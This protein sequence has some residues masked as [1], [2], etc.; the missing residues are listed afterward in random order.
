MLVVRRDHKCVTSG[1][2]FDC[3]SK[4]DFQSSLQDA[5]H[6]RLVAPFRFMKSRSELDKSNLM[7]V[8][9]YYLAANAF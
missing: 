2:H 7:A 6:M 3:I 8:A 5:T 4:L 9:N 1:K